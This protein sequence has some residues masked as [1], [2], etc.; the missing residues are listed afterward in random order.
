MQELKTTLT[1][2]KERLAASK[3]D[4][5]WLNEAIDLAIDQ[6]SQIPANPNF[7]NEVSQATTVLQG[8]MGTRPVCRMMMDIQVSN[9][10]GPMLANLNLENVDQSDA[11]AMGDAQTKVK[12][13]INWAGLAAINIQTTSVNRL[14][15]LETRMVQLTALAKAAADEA[16]AAQ[17]AS[18]AGSDDRAESP[19]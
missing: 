2:I 12:Q 19:S 6:A 17:A 3:S 18:D 16:A 7:Q 14:N 5:K 9:M 13:M 11:G 8:L 1:G 10:I 15:A 4:P